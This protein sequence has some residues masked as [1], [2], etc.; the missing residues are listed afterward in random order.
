M[1]NHLFTMLLTFS[2]IFAVFAGLTGC[3]TEASSSSSSEANLIM[4]QAELSSVKT[5]WQVGENRDLLLVCFPS[6]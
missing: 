3:E 5:D 6:L 1:K 4:I 2:L